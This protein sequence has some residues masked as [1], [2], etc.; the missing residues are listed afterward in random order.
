MNN[1]NSIFFYSTYQPSISWYT[2][3]NLSYLCFI[4]TVTR[5][6]RWLFILESDVKRSWKFHIT[7][8]P[9]YRPESRSQKDSYIQIF[10]FQVLQIRKYFYVGSCWNSVLRRRVD[11]KKFNGSAN[12]IP[13]RVVFSSITIAHVDD[14]VGYSCLTSPHRCTHYVIWLLCLQI[15]LAADFLTFF[16]FVFAMNVGK[17]VFFS[18]LMF[19]TWMRKLEKHH[20]SITIRAQHWPNWTMRK[21]SIFSWIQIL[22]KVLS[23]SYLEPC[24][25][26]LNKKLTWRTAFVNL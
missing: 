14:F 20:C 10:H 13:N 8:T 12:R 9:V 25:F 18:M 6:S 1:I 23:H 22:S 24:S 2:I 21:S 4:H 7:Q 15:K 16:N 26:P 11:E 17:P 3:Q 19:M 5:G